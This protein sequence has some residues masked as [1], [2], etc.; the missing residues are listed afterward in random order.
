MD[1]WFTPNMEL[2]FG[3][4]VGYTEGYPCNLGWTLVEKIHEGENY[5]WF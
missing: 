1:G 3:R 2:W 5:T 4:S